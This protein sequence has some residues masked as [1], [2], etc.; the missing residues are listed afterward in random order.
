MRELASLQDV[1]DFLDDWPM[2][3]RGDTYDVLI[4]ACRMAA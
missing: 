3:K 1:F 2:D 4:K